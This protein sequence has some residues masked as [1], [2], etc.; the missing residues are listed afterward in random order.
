LGVTANPK[1]YYPFDE[2][3]LLRTLA[4]DVPSYNAKFCK[5][6]FYIYIDSRSY[7]FP[8]TET[9]DLVRFQGSTVQIPTPTPTHEY[10][11]CG[12][13]VQPADA[14]DRCHDRL[15]R[16]STALKPI[17]ATTFNH[18]AGQDGDFGLD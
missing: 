17:N 15:N 1:K 9:T 18:R 10:R 4:A 12:P 14:D 3:R 5:D 6:S 8:G 7:D 2:T 11:E 13:M 16:N